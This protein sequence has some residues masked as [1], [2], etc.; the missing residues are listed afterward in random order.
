MNETD[1]YNIT[2]PAWYGYDAYLVDGDADELSVD[3]YPCVLECLAASLAANAQRCSGIADN[4]CGGAVTELP[5][6]IYREVAYGLHSVDFAFLP[7]CGDGWHYV[8]VVVCR[9]HK[10]LGHT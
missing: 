9:L 10:H 5:L 7:L 2:L 3:G 8:Y 4:A 6:E 1:V